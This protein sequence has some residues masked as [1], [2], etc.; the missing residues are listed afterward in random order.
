M[1]YSWQYNFEITSKN[2]PRLLVLPLLVF[3]H[4]KYDGLGQ[5]GGAEE[6]GEAGGEI[7]PQN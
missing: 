6:A 5:A 4:I 2:T 7:T 1:I 3:D